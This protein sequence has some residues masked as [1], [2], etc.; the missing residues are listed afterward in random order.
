MNN[1]ET[2]KKKQKERFFYSFARSFFAK[3]TDIQ[4]IIYAVFNRF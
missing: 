2:I 3:A 1:N 4:I